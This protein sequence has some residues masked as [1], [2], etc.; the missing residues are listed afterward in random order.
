LVT[1]QGPFFAPNAGKESGLDVTA[2]SFPQSQKNNFFLRQ[3]W[4]I[5]SFSIFIGGHLLK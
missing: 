4:A 5:L 1:G 3:E 2:S